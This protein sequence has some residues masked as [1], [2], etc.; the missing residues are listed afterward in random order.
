MYYV[1]EGMADGRMV[2]L[3]RQES[4][5]PACGE[6]ISAEVRGGIGI[7]EYVDRIAD[8][9]HERVDHQRLVLRQLL[10]DD[11]ASPDRQAYCP[12]VDCTRLSRLQEALRETIEVLEETKSSFKSKR[13]EVMRRK[14][15]EILAGG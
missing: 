5:S 14:L 12:L 8:E 7:E 6:T 13:L 1:E 3:K 11:A 10:A 2:A 9:L 4:P 15:V